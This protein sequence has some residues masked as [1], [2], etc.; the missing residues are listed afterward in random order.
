LRTVAFEGKACQVHGGKSPKGLASP[1]FKTGR[2]S[3]YMPQRLLEQYHTALED[4]ELLALNEEMALVEA[5]LA[6][7]LS[8]VD[9]GDSTRFRTN[10]S[11]LRSRYMKAMGR[12][13]QDKAA[14]ALTDILSEIVRGSVDSAAWAEVGTLLEQKRRLG[15]SERKRRMD[16]EQIITSG[17]AAVFVT[18]LHSSLRTRA[19][20]YFAEH[21][22]LES[23]LQ[24][25]GEDIVAA[26]RG[27]NSAGPYLP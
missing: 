11:N 19:Y 9:T 8:R 18:A 3:K 15:E 2:Y 4:T 23:Y 6:D 22:S 13:D 24:A 1:S 16:M 17:E 25:V 27:S 21:P 12:R 5:R 20:E 10:L 7:V 14:Q 26:M